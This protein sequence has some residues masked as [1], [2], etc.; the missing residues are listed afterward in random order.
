MQKSIPV[1]VPIERHC[2][3]HSAIWILIQ[4]H[5][6]LQGLLISRRFV[7]ISPTRMICLKCY[8]N[9]H[10]VKSSYRRIPHTHDYPFR[11]FYQTKICWPLGSDI[12]HRYHSEDAVDGSSTNSMRGFGGDMSKSE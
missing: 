4:L 9:Q 10:E 5:K 3:R 6:R 11:P 12:R 7:S 8:K 1:V 2:L